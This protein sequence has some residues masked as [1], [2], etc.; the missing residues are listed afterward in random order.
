MACAA[1]VSG[2]VRIRLGRLGDVHGVAAAQASSAGARGRVSLSLSASATAS[3]SARLRNLFLLTGR[4]ND[5]SALLACDACLHH[6][7]QGQ[8]RL[9]AHEPAHAHEPACTS[10]H[11]PAA[12]AD[13]ADDDDD[14]PALLAIDACLHH[15]HACE[16]ALLAPAAEADDDVPALWASDAGLHHARGAHGLWHMPLKASDLAC[17]LAEFL[18]LGAAALLVLLVAPLAALASD[19]ASDL[20]ADL[21]DLL[22]LGLAAPAPASAS[23]SPSAA[24]PAPALGAVVPDLRPAMAASARV[25]TRSSSKAAESFI[26][27]VA[28]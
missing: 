17:D 25:A 7:R 5:V 24:S 2:K 11:A 21:A 9:P 28:N 15:A 26:V 18:G 19:L 22:D 16:P 23:A 27:V 3:A 4:V 13:D 1:V 20:A 8:R 14:V 12:E 6:E 10:A